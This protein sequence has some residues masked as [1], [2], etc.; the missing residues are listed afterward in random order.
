[1]NTATEEHIAL[2]VREVARD[3]GALRRLSTGERIAV[4]FVAD[5]MKL[6]EYGTVAAA[7][8]RLGERWCAAAL[9]VQRNGV[10]HYLK[11]YPETS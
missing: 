7:A 8:V 4:A 9:N 5:D 10:E 2:K 3:P 1:M 11:N 6:L